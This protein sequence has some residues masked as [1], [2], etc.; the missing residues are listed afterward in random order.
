MI[1]IRRLP[2]VRQMARGASG[3]ETLELADSR[4]LVAI[5]ALHRRVR[6][7]ERKTV[8]MIID[9]FDGDLP[10]LNGVTLRAIRSH[11]PLVNIGMTILAGLSHVSEYGLGVALYARNLLMHSA[12]RI[13]SFIVVEF[14]NCSN[15]SPA[16][17]RVAIFTG[18]GERAVR[19]ASGHTL[20]DGRRNAGQL[21]GE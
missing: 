5:V 8:L 6:S 14:R 11:F 15:R 18:Y 7:E 13:L 10:A 9:L 12:K 20:G 4:A 21:P 19:T 2:K 1:W 17:C 3:G 16:C